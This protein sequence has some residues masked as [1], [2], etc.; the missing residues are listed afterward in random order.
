MAGSSLYARL[1]ARPP[2]RNKV[3]FVGH[4]DVYHGVPLLGGN[5]AATLADLLNQVEQH[6][7]AGARLDKIALV[8]C[9][10]DCTGRP[11]LREPFRQSLAARPTRPP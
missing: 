2:A 1:P 6:S 10:T 8:G 3:Q 7:P 9:D 11:S 4:G 5:A